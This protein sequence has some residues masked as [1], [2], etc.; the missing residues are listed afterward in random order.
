MNQFFDYNNKV[1][2]VLSALAD[3]I[4]LGA[5]W[6]VCS[7]PIVTM[8]AATAAVYHA[9]TKSI[10]F[11]Q[12]YALREFGNAL[13]QNFKQVTAA[14]LLWLVPAAFLAADLWITRQCLAQDSPFGVMYY[15]FI[16]VLVFALA[17]EFYLTAYMARFEGT[18]RESMKKTLVMTIANPVWTVA[19]AA[20]FAAFVVICNDMQ[21]LLVVF[22]SGFALVKNK[23][24]ERVFKKYRTP[25]E[26]SLEF[27]RTREYKM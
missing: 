6:F 21:F 22:P 8:G 13:K 16:V 15:F 12:G 27:E 26:L 1:F 4:V 14:W 23:I 5:L 25:E 24:L 18:V 3:C 19:L 17:W 9:V 11:G 2:R 20:V 10:V 7:L